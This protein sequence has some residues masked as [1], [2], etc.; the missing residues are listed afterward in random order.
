MCLFSTSFL[1]HNFHK[2]KSLHFFLHKLIS[3]GNKNNARPLSCKINFLQTENKK[4]NFT[5][6]LDFLWSSNPCL[7]AACEGKLC[8]KVCL[9]GGL[10]VWDMEGQ[11]TKKGLC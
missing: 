9:K 5:L 10:S 4:N 6:T 1:T 2:Q 11:D 8:S 3:F 7:G